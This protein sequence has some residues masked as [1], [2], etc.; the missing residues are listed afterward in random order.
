MPVLPDS[1][2]ISP[3]GA[4]WRLR[5]GEAVGFADLGDLLGVVVPMVVVHRAHVHR[6][7][8]LIGPHE[9]LEEWNLRL[10]S[11]IGLR[12]RFEV[13]EDVAALGLELPPQLRQRHLLPLRGYE[14][15]SRLYLDQGEIGG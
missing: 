5:V 13:A 15:L 10:T 2:D 8:D 4:G 7:G 12:E 3:S 14:G 9:L 1:R 6:Q 11:E